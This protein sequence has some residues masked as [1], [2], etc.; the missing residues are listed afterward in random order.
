MKKRIVFPLVVIFSVF[1]ANVYGHCL[2]VKALGGSNNTVG[3]SVIKTS[4]GGFVV[5]GYTKSYGAGG[6]D[7]LLTKFGSTGNRLWSK[8]LGGS[9]DEEGRSVIETYDGGIV[10]TGYTNSFG[11]AGIIFFLVSSTQLGLLSGQRF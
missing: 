3:N 11:G 9:G 6:M 8:T 5:T 7:V 2:F 10:V 4:D 1:T